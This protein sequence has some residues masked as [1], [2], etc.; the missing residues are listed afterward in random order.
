M[1]TAFSISVRAPPAPLCNSTIVITSL[2]VVPEINEAVHSY[3]GI[4]LHD[5]VKNRHAQKAIEGG[6]DGIIPVAAG[7]GGHAGSQ[8]P[9]ALLNEIRQWFDGPLLLS[10]AISHGR[11]IFA[12]LAAGA[13]F[14]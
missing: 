7:A 1:W 6:A 12:A 14:A 8:S 4:V 5:V 3:G 10:G 11:S 9:F 13:D 2:G